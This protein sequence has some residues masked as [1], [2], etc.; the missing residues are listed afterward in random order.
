VR[1]P[2]SERLESERERDDE[3]GRGYPTAV[4]CTQD[5]FAF[6]AMS[7]ARECGYRVPE[8][9]SFVGIDDVPEARYIEPA[10]TTIPISPQTL[11]DEA[12]DRLFA[13]IDGGKAESFTVP[14]MD[15][16]ER[17]SVAVRRGAAVAGVISSSAAV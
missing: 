8:D 3:R 1:C 12:M 15:V 16:I 2:R 17:A 7:V 9:I 10:L 6:S 11:A 4:F 5:N 13:L 14:S